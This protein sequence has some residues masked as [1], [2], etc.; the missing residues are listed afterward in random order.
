MWLMWKSACPA[1]KALDWS[2][3]TV[4]TGRGSIGL[5]LLWLGNRGR[6]LKVSP[7]HIGCK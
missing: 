5:N 3:N 4:K 6:K 7:D 2:P 1:F